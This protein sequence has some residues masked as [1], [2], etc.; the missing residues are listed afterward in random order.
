MVE[1]LKGG[2]GEV[3][4]KLPSVGGGGGVWFF[5][6]TKKKYFKTFGYFLELHKINIQLFIHR[7]RGHGVL[8]FNNLKDIHNFQIC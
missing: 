5:L 3:L 8:Q 6:G 4:D 7:Y 2:G 1:I